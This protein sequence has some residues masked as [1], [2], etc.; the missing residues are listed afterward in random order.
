M[1]AISINSVSYNGGYNVGMPSSS[2]DAFINM[3]QSF[4]PVRATE[5]KQNMDALIMASL[6]Q[7]LQLSMGSGSA[8]RQQQLNNLMQEML[9]GLILKSL[10]G[11][12][13]AGG[14]FP[15]H[16]IPHH[17]SGGGRSG[18]PEEKEEAE[19]TKRKEEAEGAE[20]KG[21]VTPPDGSGE[22]V[23]VNETIVVKAGEVFDGQGKTYVAGSSL[24]DG[25]QSEG[26]KPVFKLE[27]GATL[28]NVNLIGENGGAADGV[29]CYGDAT[30]ENVH[31]LDVGEDALTKKAAGH[32]VMKDCSMQNGDD[33]GIQ[34]NAPGS[35]ECYNCTFKNL[36]KAYRT[37]GG[38]TF[39]ASIKFINC[40][41]EGMKEAIARSDSPNFEALLDNS[42]WTD[43]GSVFKV[44]SSAKT[45]IV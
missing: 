16:E 43:V 27:D 4:N 21:G 22:K 31:W 36:G 5:N 37:N 10:F 30:L 44:P 24:G 20:G 18:R 28:K 32:I 17:G 29:H 23:H 8:Q 42:S 11:Q 40:T 25:G 3:L 34:D 12:G 15:G 14:G 33:K 38:K 39:D 1:S 26:Q 19:G 7:L 45:Q 41:F 2:S 9:L 35:I 6:I 13:P